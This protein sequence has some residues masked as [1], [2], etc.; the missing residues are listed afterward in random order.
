MEN[1]GLMIAM[2]LAVFLGIYFYFFALFIEKY[3]LLLLPVLGY[4]VF[5]ITRESKEGE[6]D[7]EKRLLLRNGEKMKFDW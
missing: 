1:K 6:K 4:L 2:I 5:F 7:L 3:F